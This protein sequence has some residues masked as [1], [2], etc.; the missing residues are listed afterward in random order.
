MLI[1]VMCASRRGGSQLYARRV[2]Q[3]FKGIFKGNRL[4]RWIVVDGVV[5]LMYNGLNTG[6]CYLSLK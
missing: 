3:I 4:S 5:V 2:H 6:Y 1:G